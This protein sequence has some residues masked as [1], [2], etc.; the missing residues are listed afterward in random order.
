MNLN[1]FKVKPEHLAGVNQFN[2]STNGQFIIQ[3][4]IF[5]DVYPDFPD[6]KT[7]KLYI[8]L[9]KSYEW[10]YQRVKKAKAQMQLDLKLSR[11]EL[12]NALDWLEVNYFIAR[13][14]SHK[15]QMYQTELVTAPDYDPFTNTY[16]SCNSIPFYTS[17]LKQRNQGYIMVP[18]DAVTNRMLENTSTADRTW[19]Y[20][21]LKV[22]L[23]LY[24]N[25]WLSYFG[26]V[27]PE[28][29][30]V[31]IDSIHVDPSFYYN[32]KK[33]EVQVVNTIKLLLTMGL[34]KVVKV[35]FVKGEYIGDSLLV[36]TRKGIK[37]YYVLRPYHL[38]AKK[39]NNKEL[40]SKRGSMIL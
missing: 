6:L 23:L 34:F 20:T 28:S 37:E 24:A 13:T 17:N 35:C 12:N 2:V 25:C 15:Q 10:K 30:H 4:K 31:E 19:T 14:N 38:S 9:C 39:V 3:R 32:V 22:Y 21:K 26:G 7:F 33:S 5:S 16:I 40:D 29:I 8:Y 18:A 1:S 36:S 27:N 11:N